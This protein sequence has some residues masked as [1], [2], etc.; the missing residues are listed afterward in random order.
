MSEKVS[1]LAAYGALG[2]PL[3]MAALP[4]YVQ[5][6]IYYT[7]HLGL[8]LSLTGT[9]LFAARLVDTVQDPWLGQWI[10]RL[11]RRGRLTPMLVVAALLLAMTFA[12]LWLPP[13]SGNALAAWLALALIA[14]YTAHSLLNIT[15]LAWGARLAPSTTGLTNAAGWREGAGLLGVM[16]ASALPTWLMN[17]HTWS[18]ERGMAAYSALFAVL[19]F[20]GLLALLRYAPRWRDPV[21]A[22]APNWTSTLANARF[23]QLLVPYFLNAISV[24]VPA[25]LALFF[26]ADR[27]QA[28]RWSGL[29]LAVY[30]AAGAAGLPGWTR[31]AARIGPARAWRL[32]M[33]LAVAAFIWATLLGP[34]DAPA[35]LAVCVMAGLA[36]G[37]DL[38]LP[39]VLLACLI[40]PN[41]QPAGYYGVWS[42]LGKLALALSGLTLPLLAAFG[43]Q[44]G[45]AASGGAA[46]ALAYGGLPC[47]FKLA[48]WGTLRTAEFSTSEEPST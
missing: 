23:R 43:Y 12:G 20:I 13:L 41:E 15:Y 21:V 2:M 8:A 27:L 46:L 39:P 28:P 33:A 7:T 32:G 14:V 34:G 24:S 37:A 19:L 45:A 17:S 36:L 18:A 44:P 29:F 6:P 1:A 26:I 42:L 30:F 9:V 11:A 47:L 35:Y 25:T 5:V 38:I 48:A 31:L 22:V 4:V 16:L 3:A 40:P 10:D